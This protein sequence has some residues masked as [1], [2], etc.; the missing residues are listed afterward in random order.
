MQS[1]QQ[2]AL[3]E[4]SMS[5]QSDPKLDDVTPPDEPQETSKESSSTSSS[6]PPGEVN[7]P[8]KDTSEPPPKISIPPRDNSRLIKSLYKGFDK[9]LN[10]VF[11][12][13]LGNED[14]KT[15]DF[16]SRNNEDYNYL[17]EETQDYLDYL[18]I[19]LDDNPHLRFI[20]AIGSSYAVPFLIFSASGGFTALGSKIKRNRRNEAS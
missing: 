11:N 9:G 15:V 12:F 10:K 6:S 14:E 4:E 20:I 7:T 1:Y 13:I 5:T 19:K 8:D 17:T 2:K 3:L 16:F 18:N